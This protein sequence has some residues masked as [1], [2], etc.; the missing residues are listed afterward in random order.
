MGGRR[1]DIDTIRTIA[2]VLL[3]LFAI[4]KRSRKL[5]ERKTRFELATLC[6]GSRCSA[7]ELLPRN[8]YLLK[9]VQQDRAVGGV[10]L[11]RILT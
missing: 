10:Q 3:I 2:V 5:L 11:G 9:R 4:R 6:L 7:P 1:Y 8:Q